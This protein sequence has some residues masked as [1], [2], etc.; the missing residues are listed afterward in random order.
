MAWHEGGA[1]MNDSPMYFYLPENLDLKPILSDL[2]PSFSSQPSE[3]IDYASYLV[4][5]IFKGTHFA[6]RASTGGYVTLMVKYLRKVI[7]QAKFDS[8]RTRLIKQDVIEMDKQYIVGKKSM[9]YRLC[10]EYRK[11]VHRRHIIASPKVAKRIRRVHHENI[12]GMDDVHRYL[13]KQFKRVDFNLREAMEIVHR[14]EQKLAANERGFL[15]TIFLAAEELSTGNW[16]PTVCKYGR[17]HTPLTRLLSNCRRA[18]RINGQ[19][20]VN[21]D[22]ANSQPLFFGVLLAQKQD[23]FYSSYTCPPRVAGGGLGGCISQKV[24]YLGGTGVF[25]AKGVVIDGSESVFPD[26]CAN[27]RHSDLIPED[28][29][30]YLTLVQE[31]RLYDHLAENSTLSRRQFKE[32]LFCDVFYGQNYINSKLTRAFKKLFPTVYSHIR[33]YK[34]SNYRRLAWLMQKT[35]SDYMINGVCRRLMLDY[36]EITFLTIHDSILTSPDHAGTVK[37]VMLE[38]FVKL[39]MRPTIRVESYEDEDVNLAAKT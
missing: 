36:P 11:S 2:K 15:P 23:L 14:H 20:L 5:L 38:E 19:R 31:G 35:E 10:G 33:N 21:L 8:L 7:P 30:T 26:S 34:K 4:D 22:I 1:A 24:D 16:L 3:W 18:L 25:G 39:G 9:G 32:K 29:Q 12:M 17:F 13:W 27:S 28:V 6:D 37:T